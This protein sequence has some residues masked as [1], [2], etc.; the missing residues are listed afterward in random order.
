M[1]FSAGTGEMM[2]VGSPKGGNQAKIL[3]NEEKRRQVAQ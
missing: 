2:I 1:R 3:Q